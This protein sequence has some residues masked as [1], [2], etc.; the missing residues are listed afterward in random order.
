MVKV[1]VCLPVYNRACYIG[2]CIGSILSQTF[3]DFELLIVDDGSTDD[4]VDIIRSYNDPRIR[5]IMNEHDYIGSLNLLLEEAKGKYIARMDSDDIMMPERLAV[6]YEYMESHPEVDVLGTGI[7]CFGDAE[8]DCPPFCV[9]NVGIKEL[10]EGCCV[11]HPTTMIRKSRMNEFNLRYSRNYIYLEDYDLWARA[12]ICGLCIRNIPDILLKYRFCDSQV[13]VV[14]NAVQKKGAVRVRTMLALE[15]QHQV[16][17]LVNQLE[18]VKSSKN[19][20]TVI[21]VFYNEKEEV[22]NTV[23][24]IRETAGCSVDVIVINDG[25]DDGYGYEADLVSYNV[26]YIR[27]AYNIGSSASKEKGVRCC[28]TKYFMLIDA[29]MRFYQ[30]NWPERVLH[31]LDKNDQQLLCCQTRVLKKVSGK[32]SVE[33]SKKTY[34]AYVYLGTESYIPSLLWNTS[35]PCHMSDEGQVPCILGAAYASS[36]DY[37]MKL[38]GLEGL[39][40][41]GCEEAYLSIKAW[42]QGGGCRLVEDVVVGHLYKD[43]SSY[44]A[45]SAKLIYNHL[46]IAETL[47]PVSLKNRTFALAEEK[48]TNNYNNAL[49]LL[50]AYSEQLNELKQYY[51][52][53]LC[54]HDFEFIRKINRQI[55]LDIKTRLDEQLLR[56]ENI[57]AYCSAEIDNIVSNGLYNGRMGLIILFCQYYRY[58]N[59]KRYDDISSDLFGKLCNDINLDKLPMTFKNGF[60]GIGWGLLYLVDN[61]FIELE[62]VHEEL[63]I[64]DSM[65]LNLSP[66][67]FSDASVEYGLCGLVAYVA[68]RIG[69][70]IRYNEENPFPANFIS[71][72]KNVSDKVLSSDYYSLNLMEKC[73]L[74]LMKEYGNGDWGTLKTDF[75]DIIELPIYN[76]AD[77][78]YWAVDLKGCMGY[79]IN[80]LNI[81]NQTL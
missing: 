17:C 33:D 44:S 5:L 77:Q 47:F 79:A 69:F 56:V 67:G 75:S 48:N 62:E 65:I 9:G 71:E 55:P 64:I 39:I 80:I 23:K 38:R 11:T 78:H 10:L 57:I 81:K 63:K 8:Y 31:Y 3:E 14:H 37:W 27:N 53:N 4:T 41:F 2:E 43:T 60:L 59:D 42:L 49:V 26:N 70:S 32:I 66:S 61:N 50:Q 1:S 51:H 13:T 40:T 74:I 68:A 36:R 54:G 28:R 18:Q 76:P 46:A 30:K 22:G 19:L 16:G 73:I 24:S 35:R 58:T 72:L 21:V 6:Q 15:W 34:G 7:R 45:L 29:H 25:S 20:L 12:V 52:T